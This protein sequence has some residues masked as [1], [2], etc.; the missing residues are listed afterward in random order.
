MPAAPPGVKRRRSIIC[1]TPA[2]SPAQRTKHH[3]ETQWLSFKKTIG[4]LQVRTSIIRIGLPR[5]KLQNRSGLITTK[6]EEEEE[7]E[8]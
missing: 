7:N 6:K 4:H 2:S 1:F 8:N 5:N 3:K